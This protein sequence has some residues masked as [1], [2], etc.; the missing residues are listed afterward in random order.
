ML[1]K[2]TFG[3]RVVEIRRTIDEFVLHSWIFTGKVLKYSFRI[4]LENIKTET[5]N[6]V[7]V[8]IDNSGDI[9]KQNICTR[10]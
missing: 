5:E 2:S 7:L 4:P 9:L 6:L 1:V 8:A 3:I 10:K